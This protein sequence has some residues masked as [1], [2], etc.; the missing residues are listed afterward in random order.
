MH[1]WLWF[2]VSLD[3]LVALVCSTDAFL[4]RMYR[5]QLPYH[6]TTPTEHSRPKENMAQEEHPD[7]IGRSWEPLLTLF[8]IYNTIIGHAYSVE[9]LHRDTHIPT[10]N[11][12]LSYYIVLRTVLC[13]ACFLLLLFFSF[14]CPL[15]S[16]SH[17]KVISSFFS[18]LFL[19]P[20]STFFY[21]HRLS[22][23]PPVPSAHRSKKIK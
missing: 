17:H 18:L 11:T 2:N 8:M 23:Y 21:H 3:W 14:F 15:A 22:S 12:Q 1:G 20:S 9:Y 4:E 10:V 5:C 19:L 16:L 7:W 13:I 6:Y